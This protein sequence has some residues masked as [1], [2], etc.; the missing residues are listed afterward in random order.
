MNLL[1]RLVGGQWTLSVTPRR[2][3][4]IESAPGGGV[5]VGFVIDQ[6]IDVELTEKV[7]TEIAR[8]PPVE[9]K[10]ENDQEDGQQGQPDQN[11]GIRNPVAVSKKEDPIAGKDQQFQRLPWYVTE[12]DI[13]NPTVE[14]DWD[15]KWRVDGRMAR[16]YR[17]PDSDWYFDA[18][19][20]EQ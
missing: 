8:E 11:P 9:P 16:E 3:F 5:R 4:R 17:N 12:R 7:A 6:Q 19:S 10:T 15:P 18:Y 1:R 20:E 14:V 2:G 13:M